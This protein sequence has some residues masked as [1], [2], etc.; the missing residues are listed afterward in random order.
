[1]RDLNS[2]AR[3]GSVH[4]PAVQGADSERGPPNGGASGAVTV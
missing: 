4:W 1:M 2:A 3:A